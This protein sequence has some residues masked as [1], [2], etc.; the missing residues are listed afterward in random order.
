M[1]A[2]NTFPA[3]VATGGLRPP[4][5]PPGVPTRAG[6]DLL[7]EAFHRLRLAPVGTLA[8]YYAGTLPFIL[9]LLYFCADQSHS[10]DAASRATSGGLVVTLLFLLMKTCQAVFTAQLAAPLRQQ[11][12][13]P[14]TW[15]RLGRL[16]FVQTLL[17]PPGLFVLT[18]ASTIVIPLAW[19]YAFYQNIT[20]LGDGGAESVRAT[21]GRAYRT[22]LR[23]PRQNHAGLAVLSF[24]G[25]FV[26][27][28][29]LLMAFLVPYL[30]KM[31]SGEENLFTRSGEHLL[32]TTFFA[33]LFGLLYLVLDPVAKAFYTLRCF[34]AIANRA[35]RGRPL[36]RTRRPAR[37]GRLRVGPG[38]QHRRLRRR[39][40]PP[41][42]VDARRTGVA[43]GVMLA[44]LLGLWPAHAASA[45]DPPPA[46]VA[47][48]ASQPAANTRTDR[49]PARPAPLHRRRAPTAGLDDV[50]RLAPQVAWPSRQ[51][52]P[53]DEGALDAFFR[54]IDQWL[55]ARWVT[56]K[57]WVQDLTDW[58][59]HWWNP[60]DNN[61]EPSKSTGFGRPGAATDSA[62]LMIVL[63]VALRPGSSPT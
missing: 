6:L 41:P 29:L 22:A 30:L 35:H 57:G 31:F 17:Q 8:I 43:A 4:S 42:F 15:A 13:A 36:E 56:I 47:P 34:Y 44:G 58:L 61:P 16:A 48:A 7:D 39:T 14:W 53:E 37:A 51:D 55:H 2:A 26:A 54:N 11:G 27:L 19:V 45:A 59:K 24:L 5:A 28:N 9:A 52:H 46:A 40:G 60:H 12:A 18:V 62:R 38:R 21:F 23:H 33:V 25:F 3:P 20:V 63:A 1:P 10:P 49:F 50:P 32:N